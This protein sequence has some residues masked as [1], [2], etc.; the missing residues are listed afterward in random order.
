MFFGT[1]RTL[2]NKINSG[3]CKGKGKVKGLNDKGEWVLLI[4]THEFCA[5]P[6]AVWRSVWRAPPAATM[7]RFVWRCLCGRRYY[8]SMCVCVCVSFS[9]SKGVLFIFFIFPFSFFSAFSHPMLFICLQFQLS[10]FP[11]CCLS[12]PHLPCLCNP[13]SVSQCAFVVNFFVVFASLFSTFFSRSQCVSA[14]CVCVFLC[15]L[16]CDKLD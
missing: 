10:F 15:N 8:V 7:R 12:T 3:V 11:C 2:S 9:I 4:K 5:R 14:R 16:S 1:E 13:S 6:G